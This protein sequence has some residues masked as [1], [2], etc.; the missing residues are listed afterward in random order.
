[1][2]YD[3]GGYR[4]RWTVPCT[5]LLGQH[6][7]PRR[8]TAALSTSPETNGV[9]AVAIYDAPLDDAGITAILAS[10]GNQVRE[11]RTSRDWHLIDLAERVTVSAS[12]ICRLEL[13]RREP[14]LY[15]LICVCAVL[16]R[17]LSDILRIAEDAAFPLGDAPWTR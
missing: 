7:H 4:E 8:S 6:Q 16:G 5:D 2:S 15:Q 14:S 12:V 13:A 3:T 10:I 11:A 9:I 1:M 17:R